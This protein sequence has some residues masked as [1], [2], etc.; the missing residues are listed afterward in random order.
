[1]GVKEL[2]Y[3]EISLEMASIERVEVVVQRI[4]VTRLRKWKIFVVSELAEIFT[5]NIFEVV[6]HRCDRLN[7]VGVDFKA[8]DFFLNWLFGVLCFALGQLILFLN[9]IQLFFKFGFKLFLD[10]FNR[11]VKFADCDFLG[12]NTVSIFG[13]LLFEE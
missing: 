12:L 2:F 9:N 6:E 8:L 7:L 11:L 4:G 13:K 1:M 5:D 10:V 3:S